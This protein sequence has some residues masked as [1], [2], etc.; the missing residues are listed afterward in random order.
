MYAQQDSIAGIFELTSVR[1]VAS[2]F[3]LNADSTFE[4][5]FSYGA[6]D[7][8]GKGNWRIID[9]KIIFNSASWPGNDFKLLNTAFIQG[10]PLII[11]ITA[12]NSMLQPYVYA[13]ADELKDG[14]Y[15]VNANSRGEIKLPVEKA[16]SLHLLFEFVPERIS[17]FKVD[18]QAYNIFTFTFEPWLFEYFFKNVEFSLRKGA[19]HGKHPL[20]QNEA[21]VFEKVQ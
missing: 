5:Y 18:T 20:L 3:K 10:A 17:S 16:D 9:D 8:S 14:E 13:Y 15:P 6:L 2:G 19:L 4:F 21:C 1:E 11:N 12:Q 7:R